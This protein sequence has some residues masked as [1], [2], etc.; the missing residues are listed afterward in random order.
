MCGVS[1]LIF[2]IVVMRCLSPLTALMWIIFDRLFSVIQCRCTPVFRVCSL[3]NKT[4]RFLMLLWFWL[5]LAPVGICPVLQSHV[6]LWTLLTMNGFIFII[7]PN[8]VC[9]FISSVMA[10]LTSMW[11]SSA[12]FAYGCP[13]LIVFCFLSSLLMVCVVATVSEPMCVQCKPHPLPSLWMCFCPKHS[14]CITSVSSVKAF[15]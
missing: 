2:S 6:C 5:L 13:V 9:P 10:T 4:H 14:F 3:T 8:L 15:H 11:M 7:A 12:V 1:L